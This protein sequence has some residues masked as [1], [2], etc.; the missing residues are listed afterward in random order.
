M[1]VIETAK[2]AIERRYLCDNCLGRQ[3]AQLLTGMDNAQR[4]HA[5]RAALAMEYEA[6]P[7]PADM[8]NFYGFKFRRKLKGEAKKPV[9]CE[10]CGNIFKK[11]LAELVDAA[12]SKLAGF[13]YGSFLIGTRPAGRTVIAEEELWEEIGADYCEPLKAEV[14]REAGKLFEKQTG[15]RFDRERPDVD[16]LLDLEKG[17]ADIALRSLFIYGQYKKLVRGIPQTKWEHYPETVEDIIA[18]P[19]MQQSAGTGHAL[20]AMGREDIDARCLAWRPFVAEIENPARRRLDLEKIQKEINRTGKVEV[21]S[22]RNSDKNEVR[23]IKHARPLKTYR[24][25]VK[26]EKP[27][28]KEDIERARKLAG[29][30]R[31]RTPERVAHR[32][33]DLV[34]KRKLY[35]ISIKKLTG[36]KAE[37]TVKCEAGLYAKELM[38][39]DNGRTKPNLSELLNNKAKVIEFDVIKIW[40]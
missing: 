15:V 37:I 18:G 26:F 1:E 35:S 12:T 4:G 27:I 39:G 7:Y 8:R 13:E 40:I 33:A 23:E 38:H 24:L 2:K 20:H 17:S 5:I 36:K 16:I 30:I 11:K 32:R 14:N 19:I 3:F 28:A 6:K 34:R 29:V 21:S 25:I 31:Q 9:K 22:L 10:V